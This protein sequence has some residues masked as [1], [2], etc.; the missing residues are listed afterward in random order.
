[1]AITANY[2]DDSWNLQSR[3][4]RFIYVPAPHTSE[5]LST[6]L[7]GCLLDWNIDGKLSS[8]TLDNCST[9]NSMIEKIKN[10]L[11]LGPLVKDGSLLHMRCCAHI[12]NLIVKD[13]L[14]VVKDGVNKIHDSVVYW[15]AIPKRV[16]KFKET[17][18]QLHMI[19]TK[20]LFLNCPTRWNSTYK[21]L[22]I[23]ISYKEVFCRVKHH[24]DKY[25]CLPTTTQWEFASEVCEKL[26]IFNSVTELFSGTNYPT[27][28][29]YF[30]K[31]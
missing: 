24:D 9:N 2:I 25:T 19:Y 11:H 22:D 8:I 20:S 17:A 27:A 14:E 18:K 30:S 5:R 26:K 4:L 10:K 15:T 6:V 29:L 1:M 21:M 28:N 7:V 3:I 13:G 16:E 12:L 23:A 31:V